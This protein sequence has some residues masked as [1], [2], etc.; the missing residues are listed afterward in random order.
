[1][2]LCTWQQRNIILEL[3]ED[4]GAFSLSSKRM[5][6]SSK[7]SVHCDYFASYQRKIMNF[8]VDGQDFLSPLKI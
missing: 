8:F 2:E 3:A 4:Q 5:V 1:M 6:S 7:T